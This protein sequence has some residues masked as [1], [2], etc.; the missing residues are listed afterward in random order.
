MTDDQTKAALSDFEAFYLTL[1]AEAR[2]EPIEGIVSVACVIRNRVLADLGHDNKPDWWGEGYRGVCLK[3]FQFSCWNDGADE[4][5]QALIA[6]ARLVIGDY[7][8]RTT[9][10]DDPLVRQVKAVAECVMNGS[11]LDR[12][13]GAVQYLTIGLF[14]IN[15]P[16]WARGRKDGIP[17]GSQIFFSA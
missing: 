14:R 15:P 7:A 10:P 13:K 12:T 2:G 3:P 9:Q 17:I 16:A 11:F 4:N 8:E 1:W 5:H 6:K